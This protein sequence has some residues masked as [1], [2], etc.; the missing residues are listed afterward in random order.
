MYMQYFEDMIYYY[1]YSFFLSVFLS[2]LSLSFFNSFISINKIH[3]FKFLNDYFIMSTPH[4]FS[5]IFFANVVFPIYH[6]VLHYLNHFKCNS[7]QLEISEGYWILFAAFKNSRWGVKWLNLF[8][9]STGWKMIVVVPISFV[10]L[11]LLYCFSKGL[12]LKLLI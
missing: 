3:V 1:N 2:Y 5:F 7:D 9:L 10:H 12:I 4:L 6:I 11:K 8:F